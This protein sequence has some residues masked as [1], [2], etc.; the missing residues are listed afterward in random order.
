MLGCGEL[1]PVRDAG[2]RPEPDAQASDAGDD[3]DR[4]HDEGGER[5]AALDED[6]AGGAA[7]DPLI[8]YCE[9]QLDAALDGLPDDLACGGLYS[10]V[11]LKRVN[12]GVRPYA[13][14]VPLWSDGSGKARWVHLPSGEK[15]DASDPNE[16]VFPVGTRFFKEFR[17]GGRRIETRIYAKVSERRWSRATYEWNRDETQALRS[18]GADLEDVTI[19]GTTYHVPNGRECDQCHGGRADRILGFEAISLG[20]KGASGITLTDLVEQDLLDPPPVRTKLSIGD[21][22]THLA[23][24]ALSWLHI[25]CGVSCHNSNQNAEAYSSDMFLKLDVLELDGRPAT[26]FE[27]V[28]LTL[29]VNAKTKRWGTQKRIRAGSPERSLLYNLITSREGT[30]DQMPP[31]ATK[32]VPT[33]HTRIVGQ[34]ITNLGIEEDEEADEVAAD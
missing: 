32:L 11:R 16:W 22:G 3:E 12:A 28:R 18:F 13:P 10:D 9:E 5:D 20:L 15:I 31:I 4:K 1:H 2:A 25:N 23:A 6:D 19:A 34:W 14:A 26:A 29:D 33:E 7:D 8:A 30:R 24:P 27:P 17:V 21:D